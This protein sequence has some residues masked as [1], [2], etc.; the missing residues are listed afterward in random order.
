MEGDRTRIAQVLANLLSNAAKYAPENDTVEIFVQSDATHVCVSVNDQGVGIPEEYQD[1]V[2]E[3]FTQAS[4]TDDRHF[5][6]AGLGLSISKLIIDHHQ[7]E[8]GF[9][10]SPE[11]GTTFEFKIPRWQ[12]SG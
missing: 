8:I 5:G 1:S 9:T 10:T 7:G 3:R 6:G 11:T 4:A 2:F 12:N